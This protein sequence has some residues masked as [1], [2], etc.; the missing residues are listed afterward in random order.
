[1]ELI[2]F[3]VVAGA[4]LMT[5]ALW[6]EG[7]QEKRDN[8]HLIKHFKRTGTW[9]GSYDHIPEEIRQEMRERI[10]AKGGMLCKQCGSSCEGVG[11]HE[12]YFI[13]SHGV[14]VFYGV[15]NAD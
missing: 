7:G 15:V 5:L 13:D 9:I 3:I 11:T 10:E 2:V 6:Y 4:L 8:K 1:M 12:L 14:E